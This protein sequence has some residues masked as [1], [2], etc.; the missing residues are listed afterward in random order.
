MGIGDIQS[1]GYYVRK[2]I[3]FF[4]QRGNNRIPPPSYTV[5]KLHPHNYYKTSQPDEMNKQ[6]N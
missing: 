1:L 5:P 2:S 4:D 3:I 6:V